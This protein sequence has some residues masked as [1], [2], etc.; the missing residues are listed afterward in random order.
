MLC[1]HWLQFCSIVHRVNRLKENLIGKY[2]VAKLISV[3]MKQFPAIAI[4]CENCDNLIF[5]SSEERSHGIILAYPYAH[6]KQ[7]VEAPQIITFPSTTSFVHPFESQSIL[8]Q[9]FLCSF[10][11]GLMMLKKH[12]FFWSNTHKKKKEWYT[13]FEPFYT[14]LHLLKFNVLEKRSLYVLAQYF[15][16]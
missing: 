15:N 14:L 8:N 1:H 9:R 11:S 12:I 5:T 4:K 3:S 13:N 6:E 10:L 7:N 16:E 2:I